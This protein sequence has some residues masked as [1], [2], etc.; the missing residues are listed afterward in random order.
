MEKREV[1]LPK[2]GLEN[3]FENGLQNTDFPAGTGN[4]FSF[5]IEK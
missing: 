5:C 1:N 2:W 3:S 4:L